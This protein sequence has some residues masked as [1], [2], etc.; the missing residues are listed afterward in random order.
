MSRRQQL[1]NIIIGTL[2]ESNDERNYFEDCRAVISQDMLTDEINKRLYGIIWEM[3]ACGNP[4]TDP[5][6]IFKEYGEKV[7]DILPQMLALCTDWS[8]IHK[9]TQYNETQYLNSLLYGVKYE[10]TNVQFIDYVKQ[11]IQIVFKD[12][13]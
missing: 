3:N 9:K 12:E 13:K 8:F 1:E 7:A 6:S 4:C 10:R 5:C 11:F 2:L